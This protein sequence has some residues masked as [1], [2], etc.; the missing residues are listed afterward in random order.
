MPVEFYDVMAWTSLTI[1][2]VVYA[3]FIGILVRTVM[4]AR[5]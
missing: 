3:L 1:T 4:E 5:R 2:V